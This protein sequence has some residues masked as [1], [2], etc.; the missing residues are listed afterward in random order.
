MPA[1]RS[2]QGGVIISDHN[3]N[4]T[5]EFVVSEYSASEEGFWYALE[6][7]GISY[8]QAHISDP[9]PSE[10]AEVRYVTL[11]GQQLVAVMSDEGVG[12]IYDPIGFEELEN[13]ELDDLPDDVTNFDMATDPTTGD[14]LLFVTFGFFGDE[15]RVYS[16]PELV[17]VWQTTPDDSDVYDV[18]VANLD[19]DPGLEVAWLSEYELR[20]I[21]WDTQLEQYVFPYD[22]VG[23][24]MKVGN[25]D[26][27]SGLELAIVIARSLAFVVDV[28]DQTASEIP[29]LS[30]TISL[31]IGDINADGIDELFIGRGQSQGIYICDAVALSV[32]DLIDAGFS[33]GTDGT[34]VDDFDLDGS[35]EMAYAGGS[36]STGS[37]YVRVKSLSTQVLEF[38]TTQ[39]GTWHTEFTLAD[40]DA[41]GG[42]ER[43]LVTG[44][45]SRAIN[46]GTEALQWQVSDHFVY[47]ETVNTVAF[48]VTQVDPDP[49]LELVVPYSEQIDPRIRIFDG[50]DGTLEQEVL[51]DTDVFDPSSLKSVR[52]LSDKDPYRFGVW[53]DDQLAIFDSAGNL[54]WLS[55]EIFAD[56]LD[57][58][59]FDTNE[60]GGDELL[61]A[62]SSGLATYNLPSS[63]I[64]E[65]LFDSAQYAIFVDINGDNAREL[66][67]GKTS[68]AIK[69]IDP[70]S[71]ATI[72][73]YSAASGAQS[74]SFAEQPGLGRFLFAGG[75]GAVS[76]IDLDTGQSEILLEGSG[77]DFGHH[78]VA[79]FE[80][81]KLNIMVG[82]GYAI[83]NLRAKTDIIFKNGME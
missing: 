69:V 47:F 59:L 51:L 35:L 50:F 7:D 74:I 13:F 3:E 76:Y 62:L 80:D 32:I 71:F 49:P 48:D 23:N 70:V 38:E 83:H 5:P 66:V 2:G 44:Q 64:E 10:V 77:V 55:D 16:Y 43:L 17:L 6:F 20:V 54:Q 9:F 72:S 67:I 21:D 45:R 39:W 24:D 79:K 19:G 4:G 75:N 34:S 42:L 29:G 63:S 53:G 26:D 27:D 58:W 57:Y 8:R 11:N 14:S 46:L 30:D 37:D 73:N 31:N 41:D 60:D 40:V 82:S 25:F 56:V 33:G 1:G 36:G 15:A 61:V 12:R 28:V 22:R 81:L 68:G 78:L 52:V 65:V 18:E